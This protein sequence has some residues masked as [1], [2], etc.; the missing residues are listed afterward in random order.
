MAALVV[1]IIAMII[2]FIPLEQDDNVQITVIEESDSQP[3][4]GATI[5]FYDEQNNL[6]M[7]SATNSQG[8]AS[9]NLEP[10]K[11]T[12]RASY[13]GY[14]VT[15]KEIEVSDTPSSLNL[16]IKKESGNTCQE[17]WEC[18]EWSDCAEGQKTRYCSDSNHCGTTKNKPDT[19]KNCK[20]IK[21]CEISQDCKTSNNCI[22]SSCENEKCVHE[23]LTACV[24]GDNCCPAG[25][26]KNTDTDCANS[27][28]SCSSDS[29]CPTKGNCI[30]VNCMNGACIY[31]ELSQCINGDGCC[32]SNCDNTKDSDCSVS[33]SCSLDAECFDNTPCTK[34]LCS[35]GKCT[36]TPINTCSSTIDGCCPVSCNENN[37][38]DCGTCQTNEDCSDGDSC[39]IDSCTGYP[40]TCAYTP[41][42][43]CESGDNCCPT[44]CTNQQTSPN[45]DS[46]CTQAGCSHYSDC[47]DHDSCTID[48]CN[49]DTYT[50]EYTTI[51]QCEDADGCCPSGCN[52]DTDT[53]CPFG[54]QC[55]NAAECETYYQPY[56]EYDCMTNIR[57][58][59]GN[60]NSDWKECGSS[61]GCCSPLCMDPEDD[62][63]C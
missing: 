27:G 50:C 23:M 40:L 43:L 61:D 37:D 22:K 51:T 49:L 54:V 21:E 58:E 48:S 39:T 38:A 52:I 1:V 62:P 53:D 11:Y 42:L 12:V 56:P 18:E 29:D 9:F 36:N 41:I 44:G 34:D 16:G 47:N 45:Y 5:K 60:C 26:S 31:S 35:S 57:C 59:D 24:D 3:M 17:K 6:I 63:D 14:D 4:E 33:S 10:G 28:A 15:E 55:Q 46:D 7:Q 8:T 25:C 2:F 19:K 20:E 13:F 30:V 32:P